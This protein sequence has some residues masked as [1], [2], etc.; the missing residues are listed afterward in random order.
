MQLEFGPGT[1]HFHLEIICP[2]KCSSIE[3]RR[4]SSSSVSVAYDLCSFEQ[5]I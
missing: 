1:Y 4:L 2:E 5:V 3:V